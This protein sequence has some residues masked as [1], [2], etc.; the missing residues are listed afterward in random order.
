MTTGVDV[1]LSYRQL[2]AALVGHF[3]IHPDRRETFRSRIKQLQRLKFP[4]GVNV[5]RGEKM[6][7]SARHLFQLVTAFEMIGAR[8]PAQS[9]AEIITRHWEALA[10]GYSLAAGRETLDGVPRRPSEYS[11]GSRIY[12]WI[13]SRAFGDLQIDREQTQFPA[14][15]ANASRLIVADEPSFI[16]VFTNPNRARRSYLYPVLCLS[17]LIESVSEALLAAGADDPWFDEEIRGWLPERSLA[18]GMLRSWL[19]INFDP[20][21]PS[22]PPLTGADMLALTEDGGESLPGLDHMPTEEEIEALSALER[23]AR[24]LLPHL[25]PDIVEC[26]LADEEG[27]VSPISQD[28]LDRMLHLGLL[29]VGDDEFTV[30]PLAYAVRN[31]LSQREMALEFARN[32]IANATSVSAP[33]PA[34]G[35]GHLDRLERRLDNERRTESD[36]DHH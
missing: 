9:A 36:G 29:D 31:A 7:Y 34:P 33:A 17:D 30:T 35:Q 14:N 26:I 23:R 10:V 8:I 22:Q 20:W 13:I 28:D 25:S 2:E 12:G 6:V 4:E 27:E 1:E 5:G 11:H 3:R 18:E 21:T 16:R 24:D 19:F 15:V 32:V